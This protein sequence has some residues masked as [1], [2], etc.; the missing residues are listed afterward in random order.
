MQHF[1]ASFLSRDQAYDLIVDIWKNA[2][3][4]LSDKT[5]DDSIQPTDEL[6]DSSDDTDSYYDSDTEDSYSD[7]SSNH[8]EIANKGTQQGN[9]YSLY[10][11]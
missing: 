11:I 6:S 4:E 5:N 2:R 3:P 8:S 10:R 7:S 1:F 9:F